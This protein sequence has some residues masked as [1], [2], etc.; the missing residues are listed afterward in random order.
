MNPAFLLFLRTNR[1][2]SQKTIAKNTTTRIGRIKPSKGTE[3]LLTEYRTIPG[4]IPNKT[5]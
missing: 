2:I 3:D 5:V 4:N 1:S